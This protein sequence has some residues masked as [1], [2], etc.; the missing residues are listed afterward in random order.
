M[1]KKKIDQLKS[2]INEN[3]NYIIKKE[4]SIFK[5]NIFENKK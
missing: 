4:F 2:K 3:F 5:N 1:K